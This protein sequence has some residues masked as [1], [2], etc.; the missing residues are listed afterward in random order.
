MDNIH[1]EFIM[2]LL[3]ILG[4]PPSV[5][6]ITLI[7][8]LRLLF[9]LCRWKKTAIWKL[10]AHYHVVNNVRAE[11]PPHVSP[12]PIH[13]FTYWSFSLFYSLSLDDYYNLFAWP[14]VSL[15]L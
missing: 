4:I 3:S 8:Q 14:T 7:I 10:N 12:I 9:L 2:N 1:W 11:N 6:K 15:G 5:F 13:D